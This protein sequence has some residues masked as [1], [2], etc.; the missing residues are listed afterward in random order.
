MAGKLY[1]IWKC[2][3]SILVIVMAGCNYFAPKPPKRTAVMDTETSK[4]IGATIT[5][6]E[7]S[8]QEYFART[9]A[10]GDDFVLEPARLIVFSELEDKNNLW[11]GVSKEKEDMRQCW[12]YQETSLRTCSDADLKNAFEVQEGQDHVPKMFFAVAA[13]DEQ[14]ALIVLDY[15]HFRS[16]D[17]PVDGY[18]YVLYWNGLGWQVKSRKAVY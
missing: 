2:L 10:A 3:I 4:I 7:I 16:S 15:R 11:F 17:D 5:P 14:E 13:M 9:I 18:R 8:I 6:T 1:P 12:A